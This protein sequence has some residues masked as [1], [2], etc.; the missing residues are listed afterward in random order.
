MPDSKLIHATVFMSNVET[1]ERASVAVQLMLRPTEM[2]YTIRSLAAEDAPAFTL[3][4]TDHRQCQLMQAIV[5][6]I[7]GAAVPVQ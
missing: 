1:G 6:A 4:T 3:T 5:E 2:A 7:E